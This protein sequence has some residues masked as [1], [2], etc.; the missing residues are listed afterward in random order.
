MAEAFLQYTSLAH[1]LTDI[2]GRGISISHT[3]RLSGGDINKAYALI[4]SD[5]KR[6]FM[7]A[8]AKE[9]AAFFS[10]E[11]AG[12]FAIASTGTIAVPH[13]LGAG[14]DDG[15]HVGYSFLLL[16]YIDPGEKDDAYWKTFARS[17]AALHRADCA[18]FSSGK[19]FGFIENNFIGAAEQINAP[20]DSW[21]DFFR[22]CRLAPQFKKASGYFDT[23]MNGKIIKLLERMENFI[24][25]PEAPSLLHG[26][27]WSGNLMCASGGKA[28]LIDP[29]CYCGNREADIAMT[30][31][32]GGFPC[33][34]YDA[35][36][37]AYALEA[38][39]EERRDLYNLYHLV[40]HLNL[41]GRAYFTAVCDIVNEYS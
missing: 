1:A 4:L 31:L 41:F 40:N 16:D 30:E 15:E 29:A 27:L 7:K 17:L 26:D 10:A 22:E 34:F 3:E 20:S 32:F 23:A 36:N 11:A 14:T 28:V 8:N 37:E 12:L 6:I 35:Y 19:K 2:F 38:G 9:N 39:R 13:V 18:S 5:G 25:E 24:A 21:V 33:I